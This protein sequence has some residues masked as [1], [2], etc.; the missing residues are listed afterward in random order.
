[1]KKYQNYDLTFSYNGHNWDDCEEFL[2]Q[3]GKVAVVFYGNTLPKRFN[4]WKVI[5]ANNDDMR[6]LNDPQVIC[7]LHYHPVASDYKIVN[8]KRRFV[9]PQSEFI[10][11]ITDERCEC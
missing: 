9:E 8:G 10:V 2:K 7:G 6:Y 3:G 1:M 11:K 4:G 5:D